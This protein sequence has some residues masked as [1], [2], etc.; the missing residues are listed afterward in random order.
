MGSD[1][2]LT[3][4][5]RVRLVRNIM[6]ASTLPMSWVVAVALGVVDEQSF[7]RVVDPATMVEP[8]MAAPSGANEYLLLLDHA[9]VIKNA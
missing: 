1:R 8:H 7:D 4:R 9:G 6:E 3:V 2:W 5:R